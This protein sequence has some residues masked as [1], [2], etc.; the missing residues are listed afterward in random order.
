MNVSHFSI[1]LVWW[2]FLA[3]T[4]MRISAPSI[5]GGFM[6]RS[7]LVQAYT[8]LL[9]ADPHDCP[10]QIKETISLPFSKM[11][12]LNSLK[13]ERC[14]WQS[15]S[16]LVSYLNW[17]LLNP[18]IILKNSTTHLDIVHTHRSLQVQPFNVLHTRQGDI[19]LAGLKR[20]G[21]IQYCP[22]QRAALR[23]MHCGSP[24]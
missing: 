6:S 13:A 21:Y 19:C 2:I 1:G 20:L 8:A 14:T 10:V 24:P 22:R 15:R 11:C 23:F 7:M 3:L 9:K 12:Q 16:C 18:P 17:S 4:V 5:C